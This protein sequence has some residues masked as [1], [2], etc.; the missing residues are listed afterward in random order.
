MDVTP[1]LRRSLSSNLGQADGETISDF[2]ITDGKQ[3]GY[4]FNLQG[5]L[6]LNS[7]RIIDLQIDT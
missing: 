2:D 1:N 6:V 3:R 7:K 5:T 4:A